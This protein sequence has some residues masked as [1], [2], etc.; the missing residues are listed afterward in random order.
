MKASQTRNVKILLILTLASTLTL[1]TLNMLIGAVYRNLGFVSLLKDTSP[2]SAIAEYAFGEALHLTKTDYHAL[3]GLGVVYLR[4][5][6]DSLALTFLS[7]AVRFDDREPVLK[8]WQGEALLKLGQI[9]QGAATWREA[10]GN[11]WFAHLTMAKALRA[12]GFTEAS[13]QELELAMDAPDLDA[14]KKVDLLLTMAEAYVYRWSDAK[15]TRGYAERALEISP[16][17][18]HAHTVMAWTH[19]QLGEF[20]QAVTEG[21][22]AIELGDSSNEPFEIVGR[23][24]LALGQ[25]DDAIQ[26]LEVSVAKAPWVLQPHVELGRAYLANGRKDLAAEQFRKALEISPQLPEAVQG[27]QAATENP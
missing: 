21:K 5:G 20:Q 4:Q 23:A 1:L 26:F 3:L 13:L 11:S 14:S 2:R 12:R 18:A 9:E 6:K 24:S 16:S 25:I 8:Y 27:L 22:R 19:L 17:N 10:A 7:Q 15:I